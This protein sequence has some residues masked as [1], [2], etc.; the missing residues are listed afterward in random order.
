[1]QKFAASV[2]AS[3]IT[4]GLIAL[5]PMRAV[6][7]EPDVSCPLLERRE[8]ADIGITDSTPL[9][10]S[11]YA[12]SAAPQE[13]PR[14]KVV[15]QSCSANL[16]TPAGRVAVILTVDKFEGRVTQAQVDNWL[17]AV[18]DDDAAEAWV[19]EFGDAT[20]ERGNYGLPTQ[21]DD[22]S[23]AVV[24]E[25]Y[26]A[27]DARVGTHHMSL[28]IHLPEGNRTQMP[29]MERARMILNKSVQRLEERAFGLR[30]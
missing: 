22:G 9:V 27:C 25:L 11:G 19:V 17:K 16:S 20:C 29:S 30:I 4:V 1:M 5:S 12:W 28:N 18:A 2:A 26:V 23:F 21:L 13:T 3:F 7:A 8:L 24:N 14:A 6:A 10:D 15:S